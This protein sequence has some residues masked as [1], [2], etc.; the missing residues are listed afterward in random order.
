MRS[1]LDLLRQS[2]HFAAV[3]AVVVALASLGWWLQDWSSRVA[4][5]SAAGGPLTALDFDAVLTAS[6]AGRSFAMTAL[7]AAATISAVVIGIPARKDQPAEGLQAVATLLA[8]VATVV[9]IVATVT[10]DRPADPEAVFDRWSQARYGITVEAPGTEDVDPQ[11][12]YPRPATRG[13]E[14]AE[15]WIIEIAPGTEAPLLDH[16]MGR[17]RSEPASH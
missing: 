12:P 6:L 15:T 3:T 16:S 9:S 7:V 17:P 4:T 14:G 13:P 1:I 11:A 8:A 5:E 2:S 10:P